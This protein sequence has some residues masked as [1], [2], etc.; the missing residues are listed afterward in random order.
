MK[1]FKLFI[2]FNIILFLTS[3]G[4]VKE[5]FSSQK[6]NNS[7]EFLVEKKSPLI[8]PPDYNE[9]PVPK[10]ENLVIESNENEIKSL[11]SKTKNDKI[12]DNVDEKNK[13]FEELL[14]KKIKNN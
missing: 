3:C 10:E 11:I 4:S 14:L 1:Q 13:T 6:K 8:M 5:G 2:L 12:V 9:L 7:D